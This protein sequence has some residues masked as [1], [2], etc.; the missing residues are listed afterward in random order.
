MSN[1]DSDC[2][3]IYFIDPID[4]LS[5]IISTLIEMEYESY[6]INQE[7]NDILLKIVPE[8]ENT[9]NVIFLCINNKEEIK[10]CYEYFKKI[11]EMETC[12][13]LCGAFIFDKMEIGDRIKFL[14]ENV[15][16]IE[17]SDISKNTLQTMK[18][19]LTFFEAKSKKGYISTKTYDISDAFFYLPEFKQ[20]V[21]GKIKNISAFAFSCEINKMFKAAFNIN[22]IIKDAQLFLNGAR[23]TTSLKILGFSR[24]NP[25]IFM[26]KYCSSKIESNKLIST[27]QVN[28]DIKR[29]IHNYIKWCLKEDIKVRINSLK[30]N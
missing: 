20:P 2:V 13:I 9:R 30:N 1:I 29:K 7:D 4:K 10:E 5:V 16:M 11:K 26:F 25:N 8:D 6:S 27:E 3:K 23:V 14:Q 18:K 12:Q 15:A 24:E 17:F 19:I 22:G 21:Q 28:P